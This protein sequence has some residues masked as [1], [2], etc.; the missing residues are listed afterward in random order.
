MDQINGQDGIL[1]MNASLKTLLLG[2]LIVL[3]SSCNSTPKAIQEE[4][5]SS[6]PNNYNTEDDDE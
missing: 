1:P 3:L 2:L 6:T 4:F 5:Q